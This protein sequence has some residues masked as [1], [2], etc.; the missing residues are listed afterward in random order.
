MN[1]LDR[2]LGYD[3]WTTR[4]LLLLCEPLSYVELSRPFDMSHVPLRSIFANVVRNIEAWA[5]I[6]DG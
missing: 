3:A 2:L 5:N 1:L 4:Q 6:L